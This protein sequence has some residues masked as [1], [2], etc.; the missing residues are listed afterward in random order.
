MSMVRHKAYHRHHCK[1]RAENVNPDSSITGKPLD[2][3]RVC[4]NFGFL[5]SVFRSAINFSGLYSGRKCFRDHFQTFRRK[6][7]TFFWTFCLKM[8]NLFWNIFQISE[9]C[10]SRAV[11]TDLVS[12]WYKLQE[13]TFSKRNDLK[14][15][16]YGTK[17]TIDITYSGVL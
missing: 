16:W 12:R 9:I 2:F 17:R 1:W 6:K 13:S 10:K 4:V 8:S 5:R 11:N 7:L 3:T 14:C 15:L